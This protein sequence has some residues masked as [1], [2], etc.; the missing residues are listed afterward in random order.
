[1]KSRLAL[2]IT[3]LGRLA[4]EYLVTKLVDYAQ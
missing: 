4:M 2:D 3:F 1:M